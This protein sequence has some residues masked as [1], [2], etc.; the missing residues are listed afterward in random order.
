MKKLI[1]VLTLLCPAPLYAQ[2]SIDLANKVQADL[3]ALI[4]SLTPTSGS[5]VNVPAGGDLQAALNAAKPGDT[6]RLTAGTIYTGNFI[7]PAKTGAG[8][9]TVTTTGTLPA[10]R[11][12]PSSAALMPK[13]QASPG[14]EPAIL[15]APGAHHWT[16]IGLEVLPNPG[17]FGEL[18]RLG[19]G[20]SAQNTLASVPHDL[21]VD[22][23][24]LH[25][26]PIIGQKRGIALNSASTTITNSYISDIKLAGQDTQAIAGWNGPGPFT[27][28]NNYLEAA[29]ENVLFGGSDPPIAQLV[30]SDIVI[31]GNTVTKPLAWRGLAW[32]V[33]NAFELKNARRVRFE[34]NQVSNVWGPTQGGYPIQLTPR[35]QDG[36]CPWCTVEDVVIVNNTFT[37]S[38]GA[39]NLLGAD[40]NFPSQRMARIR[41]ASNTFDVDPWAW[42][43]A[44]KLFQLL[45]GPVDVTI[46]GNTATGPHIG[47]VL[48]FDGAPKALRLVFTNNK[49]PMSLYGIFGGGSSAGGTP[50]HAWVDYTESGTLSGNVVTP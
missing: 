6:I 15:T 16:L 50:P 29:G 39:V 28:L 34:G 47:S 12:G 4:A 18:V 45:A 2:S 40:N 23:C 10:G 19:D 32:Q 44:D 11:V 25:G 13:L 38:A 42:G 43:G 49:Y 41:I 48:Y 46:D 21:V 30:P 27:I 33:K 31:S 37:G 3:T 9:I 17:G 1:L 5:V 8:V 22:R 20:S 7:L 26:D 35:N 24:Y 36:A 14:G